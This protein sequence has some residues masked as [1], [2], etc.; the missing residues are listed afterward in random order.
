LFQPGSPA[1]RA[2]QVALAW[3]DRAASNFIAM[4]MLALSAQTTATAP[5]LK[6]VVANAE[7]LGR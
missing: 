7:R 1:G 6:T 3:L 5:I 4:G 2:I